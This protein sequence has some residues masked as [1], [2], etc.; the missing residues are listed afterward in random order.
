MLEKAVLAMVV[1]AHLAA[2]TSTQ[3]VV[4]AA[5]LLDNKEPDHALVAQTNAGITCCS[6]GAPTGA[7]NASNESGEIFLKIMSIEPS[8]FHVADNSLA[9]HHNFTATLFAQATARKPNLFF[10]EDCRTQNYLQKITSNIDL[11]VLAG[12][13]VVITNNSGEG[14]VVAKS[15]DSFDNFTASW[16]AGGRVSLQMKMPFAYSPHVLAANFSVKTEFLSKHWRTT[17]QGCVYRGDTASVFSQSVQEKQTIV[18]YLSPAS[19][20]AITGKINGKNVLR[21]NASFTTPF[22]AMQVKTKNANYSLRRFSF[23][24]SVITGNYNFTRVNAVA[25]PSN[26][27]WGKESVQADLPASG[28]VTVSIISLFSKKDFFVQPTAVQNVFLNL[29]ANKTIIAAGK[30]VGVAV[31]AFNESG[32]VAGKAINFSFLSAGNHSSVLSFTNASGVAFAEF[33]MPASN[34]F[35]TASTSTPLGGEKV[36]QTVLLANS[37]SEV[38]LEYAFGLLAAG[39]LVFGAL[40]AAGFREAGKSVLWLSLRASVFLIVL[41]VALS[42]FL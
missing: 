41:S 6:H 22:D 40:L 31:K 17:R 20:Q 37:R 36:S 24:L 19:V 29:S 12:S 23:P 11:S 13:V 35:V 2:C 16:P 28:N 42:V 21:V 39:V 15:F 32:A 18:F 30:R 26:A 14:E 27:A 1:L 7:A 10:P 9:A 8:A 3:E 33:E 25:T 4:A 38:L 34:V 5:N